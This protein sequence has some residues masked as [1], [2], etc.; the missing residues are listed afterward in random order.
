M[1]PYYQNE[2][3][4]LYIRLKEQ[5]AIAWASSHDYLIKLYEVKEVFLLVHNPPPPRHM[6]PLWVIANQRDDNNFNILIE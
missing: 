5:L 6:M 4:L 3:G 2:N 1:Y